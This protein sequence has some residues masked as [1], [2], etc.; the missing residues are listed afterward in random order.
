MSKDYYTKGVDMHMTQ[1]YLNQP[2]TTSSPSSFDKKKKCHCK[3]PLSP[4][5]YSL[6]NKMVKNQYHGTQ[7]WQLVGGVVAITFI[8]FSKLENGSNCAIKALYFAGLCVHYLEE[9]T[10]GFSEYI[11][12]GLLFPKY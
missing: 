5:L 4:S 2:S 9:V 1:F 10:V 3:L 7:W 12:T 6:I 11:R 8:K